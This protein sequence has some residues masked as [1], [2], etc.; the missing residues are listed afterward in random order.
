MD[1]SV[2]HYPNSGDACFCVRCAAPLGLP[3]ERLPR[4]PEPLSSEEAAREAARSIQSGMVLSDR[5]QLVRQIGSGG[6]GTVFEAADLELGLRVAVKL[7]RSSSL[8]D[9][10]VRARFLDEARMIAQLRNPH[11][12]VL[13]DYDVTE[14]GTPYLVMELLEGKDVGT[15]LGQGV[16]SPRRAL[17]IAAQVCEALGEAHRHGIVHRDMKPENVVLLNRAGETDFVKVVDFGVAKLCRGPGVR[18]SAVLGT[19]AYVSPEM[20]AGE[21]L[22]GRSDLYAV[23]IMLWEMIVGQ[24]PFP[25]T[26]QAVMLSS[27]LYAPRKWPR[28][29]DPTVRMADPIEELLTQ[30]VARAAADRP[31]SAYELRARLLELAPL[32]PDRPFNVPPP[33]GGPPWDPPAG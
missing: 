2:C 22:D 28:A 9:P 33:T 16:L 7:L 24:L 30:L 25:G 14:T 13:L 10:R 26:N 31:A 8:R 21:P 32:A 20:L 12:V 1:C 5:Y 17:R 23:G 3:P 6:F 27:H 4:Q 15:L 18:T 29:I 11:I 19:P